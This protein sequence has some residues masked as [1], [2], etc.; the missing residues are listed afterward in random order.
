VLAASAR[1][2]ESRRVAARVV[3]VAAVVVAAV[4]SLVA[5]GVPADMLAP[6]RW[7]DLVGGLNRGFA[8][9]PSAHWP[10]AGTDEWV[11]LTILLAIPLMGLPAAA[12]ALWPPARGPG[13][14]EAA[15][16]RRGGALLLLL[17]LFGLAAAQHPLPDNAARGAAL[18][19]LLAAWLFLPRLAHARP[20][21]AVAGAG[22]V[23][24]AGLAALPLAA[25]IAPERPL[26]EAHSDQRP[27]T[28]AP[29][30]PSPRARREER[31]QVKRRTTAETH[32][33][34]RSQRRRSDQGAS[35]RSRQSRGSQSRNHG[36]G[37]ETPQPQGPPRRPGP[38]SAGGPPVWLLLLIAA[39]L[40]AAVRFVLLPFL[41][42]RAARG[43]S[44]ADAVAELRRALERLGWSVPASVTL[45]ELEPRLA[46]AAGSPAARYA[47]RLRD[48]R[49][50]PEVVGAPSAIDRRALR[51]SLTE[52][53]GP[54]GRLRGLWALPPAPITSL[55]RPGGGP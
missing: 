11:R 27:A 22:A 29:K 40:V 43:T 38:A 36:G 35:E 52:G 5:I 54:L 4:A 45:A 14:P 6:P 39:A 17:T 53:H 8:G 9:V 30:Q 26:I 21:A 18:L 44:P 31:R 16:V 19:A 10:Y 32:R 3:R 7:P 2:D 41:R 48:W 55:A 12:F 49:F 47:R 23:L 1:L 15:A 28:S 34:S 13:G 20:A 24:A 46:E 37:G 50:S 42:R 33:R 25:A 51:R